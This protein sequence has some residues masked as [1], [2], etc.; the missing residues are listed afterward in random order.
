MR[1]GSLDVFKFRSHVGNDKIAHV[2]KS[3]TP[4][5]IGKLGS[6]ELRALRAYLRYKQT[7]NRDE[8]SAP[9]RKPLFENAGVHPGDYKTFAAWA[10]FWLASVLPQMTHIGTWFNF[11]ES[12][13]IRR[14]AKNAAVYHSY[15]LEPYRFPNPWSAE[16]AGKKVV[17][18]SPFSQTIRHQYPLREKIWAAHP[19]VMPEFDLH[20]V[21]CP[22]HP[23]LV[24]PKHDNWFGSLEDMKQQIVKTNFDVLLVGAGAYSLP[25]C[26]FAKSLG[27][28]GIHLGGN[29][30]CSLAFSVVAGLCRIPRSITASL[31]TR[32]SI[33]WRRKRR[34]AAKD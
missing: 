6:T 12:R 25:L 13:I 5:A 28:I 1:Y 30:S 4:A 9:F 26:S 8:T 2:I 3:N 23:H 18:V 22:T 17:V 19:R 21:Q 20:T 10:D 24:R 11:N 27:K 15:G 34:M 16:L 14:Y 29:P 33:P 7:Q 31:T 32:G